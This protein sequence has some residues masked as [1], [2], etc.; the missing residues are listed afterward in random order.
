L[1]SSAQVKPKNASTAIAIEISPG[2]LP[3]TAKPVISA[4]RMK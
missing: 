1:P 2:T 4:S 3:V